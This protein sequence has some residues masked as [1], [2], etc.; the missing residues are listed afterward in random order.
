MSRPAVDKIVRS[1]LYEGYMLYPYRRSAL[2]NQHRWNFGLVYPEGLEPNRMITE[3]LISGDSGA[4]S[5]TVEVR[6]L[7]LS[8]SGAWEETEERQI[9]IHNL[10]AN[11]FDFG[12]VRGEI[13][14][15][16]QE[17]E[18]GVHKIRV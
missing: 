15:H 2:K 1:L 13:V 3:C 8:E 6:F 4:E 9:V 14:V 12:S 10:G 7:Q 18:S 16:Q 17:V 11:G 5:V